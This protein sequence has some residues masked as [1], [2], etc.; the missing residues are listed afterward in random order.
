MKMIIIR[1]GEI[2]RTP[3]YDRNFI[4]QGIELAPL[5]KL[6]CKQAEEAATDPRLRGSQLI[7]SSPYTRCMQTAAIISRAIDVPLVVEIDLHEWLPDINFLNRRGEGEELCAEFKVH[8]GRWPK[9]ETHRWETIDMMSERLIK[10]LKQYIDYDKVIFVIHG[11]LMHQLKQYRHV[12]HCFID[13]IDFN[14]DYVCADWY[15]L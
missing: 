1:H 11:M 2:D 12:P 8:K 5:T 15:D 14:S 10:T 6:G 4:G 3:C 13:E 9:G 7:V